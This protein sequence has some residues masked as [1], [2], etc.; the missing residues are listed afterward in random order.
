MMIGFHHRAFFCA[1]I[2]VKHVSAEESSS[3]IQFTYFEL[4][5]GF[6]LLIS[7]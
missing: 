5:L 3:A 4:F 2:M 6:S 1:K 7:A